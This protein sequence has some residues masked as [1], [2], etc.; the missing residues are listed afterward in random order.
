MPI[1]VKALPSLHQLESFFSYDPETGLL[2]RRS[3]GKMAGSL[4]KGTGHYRVW[5]MKKSYPASRIAWKMHY[6]TEPEYVDHID[7]NPCNNQISNL[8][9]VSHQINCTNRRRKSDN[10]SGITGINW[11]KSRNKWQAVIG[12]KGKRTSLGYYTTL[13]DAAA[14]RKSAENSLGYL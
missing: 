9:S 7:R 14:A 2:T 6:G 8:R 10:T 1:R 4:D 11:H 12:V 3:N 5:A 13:L